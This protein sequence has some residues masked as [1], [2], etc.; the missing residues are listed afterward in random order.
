M[1]KSICI[2][3]ILLLFPFFSYSKGFLTESNN[4]KIKKLLVE[5][6]Y[7]IYTGL[8]FQLNTDTRKINIIPEIGFAKVYYLKVNQYDF[9]YS[10][11]LSNEIIL[12]KNI[13]WG[14]KTSP[15]VSILNYNLGISFIYY[16]D[17]KKGNFK[18]RPEIGINFKK[19]KIA[20][21]YNIPTYENEAFTYLTDA[22]LQLSFNYSFTI[23]SVF[24]LK[25]N[26]N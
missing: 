22:D 19:F 24:F 15:W 8:H 26:K 17:F 25:V 5:K 12:R 16:T 1:K 18:I 23:Y 4:K 2:I 7:D 14:F 10:W 11:S 3:I 6:T 20:L 21:G 13:I 9:L